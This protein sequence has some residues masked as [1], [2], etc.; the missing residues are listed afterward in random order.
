MRLSVRPELFHVTGE[1]LSPF[2][3]PMGLIDVKD[4]QTLI[5]QAAGGDAN[6][7]DEIVRRYQ[8]PAVA[9][10]YSLLGS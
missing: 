5:G 6:A 1:S 3:L 2:F 7:F 8:N 9:Y 4:I 10:A